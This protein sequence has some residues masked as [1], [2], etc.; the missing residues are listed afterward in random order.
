MEETS[1]LP[2][3]AL[4]YDVEITEEGRL[5]LHVPFSPGER[6]IVFVVRERAAERFDDLLAASQSSLDF[7]DN[8][9]DD[10]DWNSA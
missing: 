1:V 9:Y 2:Q 6:V 10:E 8:P 5:E 4:R 7:W 3:T